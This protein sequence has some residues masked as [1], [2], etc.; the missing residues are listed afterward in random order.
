MISAQEE[1]SE[2]DEEAEIDYDEGA[3]CRFATVV[4]VDHTRDAD[5]P[6]KVGEV[7][8]LVEKT[9][10]RRTPPGFA[11]GVCHEQLNQADRQSN[12]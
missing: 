2:G 1:M 4:E 7:L 5:E 12:R 9:D 3:D 8:V 6:T 10:Q 11:L